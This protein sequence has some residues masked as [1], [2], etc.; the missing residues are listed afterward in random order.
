MEVSKY[1]SVYTPLYMHT[2]FS[3]MKHLSL[4]RYHS[5][6]VKRSADLPS[7]LHPLRAATVIP[8]LWIKK[9]G[10]REVTFWI[11][12]ANAWQSLDFHRESMSLEPVLWAWRVEVS[13]SSCSP[14]DLNSD[15]QTYSRCQK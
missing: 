15:P 8:I 2:Y 7:V 9:V 12:G 3:V 13:K 6:N 4:D 5:K 10:C 14:N 1:V 11:H